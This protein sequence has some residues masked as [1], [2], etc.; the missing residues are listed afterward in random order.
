VDGCREPRRL[1]DPLPLR[2]A[3]RLRLL[4]LRCDAAS[5]GDLSAAVIAA[6][7]GVW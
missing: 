7:D 1:V 6:R 4:V 2:S 5:G 3:A